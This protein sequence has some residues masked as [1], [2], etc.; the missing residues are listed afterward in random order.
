MPKKKQQSAS[1]TLERSVI[2]RDGKE[3]VHLNFVPTNLPDIQKLS[4][5]ELIKQYAKEAK[6]ADRR[7]RSI[8]AASYNPKFEGIKK[9]AYAKAVRDIEERFGS[10]KPGERARFDKKTIKNKSEDDI[11]KALADVRDFMQKPSS[12]PAALKQVYIQRVQTINAH[13]GTNFKWQE[14]ADFVSDERFKTL[15]SG[16]GSDTFFTKVGQQMKPARKVVNEMNKNKNRVIRSDNDADINKLILDSLEAESISIT[17][18]PKG[19]G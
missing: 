17:D 10:V 18:L 3:Q 11:R 9:Y 1:Y 13:Y 15:V 6:A 19:L 4:G 5:E 16:Y 8:E 12:S 14:F 2:I 7:L